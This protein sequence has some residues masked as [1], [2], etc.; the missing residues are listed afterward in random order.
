MKKNDSNQKFQTDDNLT[1][2]DEVGK[3]VDEIAA[4]TT[5]KRIWE[6]DFARG[7]MILFVVWDH[8]MFDVRITDAYN[9]ALF[10][11]L[12]SLS[13]SYIA[14]NIRSVTHDAFVSLFVF[15]SGVSCCFSHSNGKRAVK[16]IVCALLLTSVTYAATALI[17]ANLTIRF[18]VIHAIALSVLLWTGLEWLW[19]KCNTNLKKN[20]FGWSVFAVIVASLVVGYCAKSQPSTSQNSVFFFLIQHQTEDNP[21]YLKFA[22]GDYLPFLPDFGWF[23]LGAFLGKLLYPERK[24]LFPS[25]NERWVVPVTFCGRHSLWIYFGSQVVMFVFIYLFAIVLGWL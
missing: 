15:T 10:Q 17:G 1:K 23:L 5:P 2:C 20:I 4:E 6:V 19:Q 11:W 12:Y 7:F 3:A 21:A 13:K 9:T 8:F 14:S 18:N 24:S 25:M 16:M 22:G